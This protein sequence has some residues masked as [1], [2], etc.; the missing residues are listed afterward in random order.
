MARDEN[1]SDEIEDIIDELPSHHKFDPLV[2]HPQRNGILAVMC[3][4]LV[5]IVLDNSILNVAIPT[6]SQTLKASDQQL[7]WIIDAYTLVFAGLLLTAGTLGDRFG[8]RLLLQVGLGI[9]GLASLIAAFAD[10]PLQLIIGRGLMG[11]GGAAI[12]PSTLSIITNVFP[13]K[14]RT[15]AIGIWAAFAGI[16]VA[17]G[18]LTGGFLIE[19]FWWGSVFLVNIPVVIF[20]IGINAIMVPESKAEKAEKID[21]VGAGLSIVGL[22]SLL[23]GIIIGSVKNFTDSDVLGAFTLAA[24]TLVVFFIWESKSD[25]PM[26]QIRFFKDK[27]FSAGALSITL[28]FFAMFGMSFLLTQYLQSVLGFTPLQSGVRFIPFA[29]SMIVAAPL[30]AKLS[31][32]IGT[33]FTVVA[34]LTLVLIALLSMTTLQV[35]DTYS[36]VVWMM[37]LMAG[38]MGLTM[39]PATSSVMNSVPREKAGVGSAMNDT[40]R[41]VGGALGLAISGS[42]FST[43]YRN[44]LK[45]FPEIKELF[46]N[47]KA[48][49]VSS[50]E[51]QELLAG[52]SDSLGKALGIAQ[53]SPDQ[54]TQNSIIHGAQSSFVHG[55]HAGLY[56]S[57]AATVIAIIV[58]I[59]WLPTHSMSED[60]A[61]GIA[62]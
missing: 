18:P 3:L 58:A 61:A 62:H 52:I 54:T 33:K 36:H 31:V 43:V 19:H 35:D 20:G 30:S 37:I 28:V 13:P 25:H 46:S 38:G 57:A 39:A 29:A 24:I 9:F 60:Q 47:M 50:A 56:M 22:S 59:L 2:G 10:T 4:S 32:K 49:G 14:E 15:R 40:T 27:R 17:I 1:L 16:G 21:F 55:M 44:K 42:V 53:T 45:D 6:I 23:Y 11:I 48:S 26:L 12:M 8:R 34:G 5:V 51:R 7:L 41:M